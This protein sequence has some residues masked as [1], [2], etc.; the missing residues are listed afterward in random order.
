MTYFRHLRPVCLSLCL[1]WVLVFP[2]LSY[3]QAVGPTGL[4]PAT[5]SSA[6]VGG[7]TGSLKAGLEGAAGPAG[8]KV[9]KDSGNLSVIIGRVIN[10]AL[11]LLGVLLLGYLIYAGFKWMTAEKPEDVTKAKD[12]IKNAIIGIVIIVAAYAISSYVLDSLSFVISDT[13]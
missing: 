1:S 13:K 8:Y 12:T 6:A 5:E 10:V 7:V 11:S 2:A 4:P 3:V 9:G